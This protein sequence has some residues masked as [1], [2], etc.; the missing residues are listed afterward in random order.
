MAPS[1]GKRKRVDTD[2]KVKRSKKSPEPAAAEIEDA[3]ELDAQEIFRRHFEAQ[4]KPLPE[5]KKTVKAE[6][7]VADA[8]ESSAEESDEEQDSDWDGLS[9]GQ[10]KAP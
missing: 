1:L 5:I 4:F 7:A 9:D 6:E 2:S 3:Q 8:E 10:G